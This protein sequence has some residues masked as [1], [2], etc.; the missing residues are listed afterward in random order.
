M[1]IVSLLPSA[2]EI[3][4]E[5]GLGKHL[6]GVSHE[7][8]YPQF[9][10]ELPN[11]T[12][13]LIPKEASSLEIDLA[14]R[15]QLSSEKAIYHLDMDVLKELKPDF[16]VTQSLCEVCAVAEDEVL[17]AV[18]ELP[19]NARIINLEPMTLEDVFNTLLLV[20]EETGYKKQAVNA[21]S[22]LRNRV[23]SVIE[24]TEKHIATEFR[25]DIVFLEWIDPPFNAGHWTPELIEYA[26]GISL[27][28]NKHRPSITLDWKLIVN[29]D[30]EVLFIACCGYGLERTLQDMSILGKKNEWTSMRSVMQNKVY[31]T[32]GNAYFSRPGPRLVDGLE[33]M[34]HALHPDVHALP[35]HLPAVT[36]YE[37]FING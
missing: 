3:V 6:V 34:A 4:C 23:E 27:L 19:G 18:C 13:S 1:R 7:C 30:P 26:G 33:I 21:V 14:V 24:K 25:P 15:N 8:D 12:R 35:D 16:I 9:V 5:I 11:V 20:G 37:D 10:K 17:D 32:D 22:D 2:T 28:S 36:K 29:T 31:L